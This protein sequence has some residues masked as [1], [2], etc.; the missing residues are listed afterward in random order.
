[1]DEL[2][3]IL[4]YAIPV[5]ILVWLWL[6][7]RLSVRVKLLVTL[8]LPLLYGLH[9]QGLQDVK[10][11]PAYQPL[12]EE[13]ELI[14]ADVVEPKSGDGIEGAINLWIRPESDSEPRVHAL[15]YTRE[16]HKMLFETKQ[17][18]DGGQSQVG[19]LRNADSG[20]GAAIGNEQRLEF[21]NAARSLLPPKN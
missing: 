1:M 13:F 21:Q 4:S 10:G 16:M 3:L 8:A 15:P 6:A 7:S 12:P 17:R 9:W 11:W 20:Q 19:V 14:A 5:A 18:M 2:T